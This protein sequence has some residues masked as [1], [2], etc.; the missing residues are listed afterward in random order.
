[1]AHKVQA[2]PIQSRFDS[3][4]AP[5]PLRTRIT[6]RIHA[7]PLIRRQLK[8]KYTFG[9]V[10]GM[11]LDVTQCAQLCSAWGAGTGAGIA[12]WT[13]SPRRKSKRVS[14]MARRFNGTIRVSGDVFDVMTVVDRVCSSIMHAH[15]ER[16]AQLRGANRQAHM[17]QTIQ[18]SVHAAAAAGTRGASMITASLRRSFAWTLTGTG[19]ALGR[20]VHEAL[21]WAR[22]RN[23]SY[24]DAAAETVRRVEGSSAAAAAPSSPLVSTPDVRMQAAGAASPSAALRDAPMDTH[25]PTAGECP[26]LEGNGVPW[27]PTGAAPACTNVSAAPCFSEVVA[28]LGMQLTDADA[29]IADAVRHWTGQHEALACNA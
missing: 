12:L 20:A 14:R 3:E 18:V 22:R 8:Y 15:N 13:A 26:A 4:H 6:A 10:D 21:Q 25:T 29:D 23:G 7:A 19:H 5:L 1:M 2:A 11:P 28:A 16:T 9:K 27:E 24:Y 17:H